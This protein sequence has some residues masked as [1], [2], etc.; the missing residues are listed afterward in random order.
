MDQV[1]REFN[2]QS[3][4]CKL[5]KTIYNS[6]HEEVDLSVVEDQTLENALE[7]KT[8][9]RFIVEVG[10]N[11]IIE[12]PVAE[13]YNAIRSMTNNKVQISGTTAQQKKR[14][15]SAPPGVC[16][17]SNLGNTCFMNSGLQCLTHSPVLYRYFLENDYS[18]EINETN[19]LG[20]GGAVALAF[21]A[22]MKEMWSGENSYFSPNDFKRVIGKYA[23]QF[24]G[25]QQQDSQELISFI[26]DGLHEDL[27]RI[28]KKPATNPVEAKGREDSVVA[29]ESWD[30]HKLRNDSIIVDKFQGQLKSTLHCPKCDNFSIIFDPFMYLSLPIPIEKNRLINVMVF[31]NSTFPNEVESTLDSDLSKL[32]N[33]PTRLTCKVSKTG[34]VSQLRDNVLE[35][36]GL[37][38]NEDHD[39]CV[40]YEIF[41]NKVYKYL[42]DGDS[43][44]G[45][46]DADIIHCQILP[47]ASEVIVSNFVT[48]GKAVEKLNNLP[49]NVH[50][51]YRQTY[52]NTQQQLP[53]LQVSLSSH[54]ANQYGRKSFQIIGTPFVVPLGQIFEEKKEDKE[55]SVPTHEDLYEYCFQ[56]MLRYVKDEFAAEI[57][58]TMKERNLTFKDFLPSKEK[59]EALKSGENVEENI[60][61]FYLFDQEGGR[62][63]V[64]D[65]SFDGALLCDE[66]EF[67]PYAPK[68]SSARTEKKSIFMH[69]PAFFHDKMLDYEKLPRFKE[70]PSTKQKISQSEAINIYQ[71]LDLYT[72]KEKLG[73]NDTW[74]CPSCKEHVEATK[75]F[76]I[77]KAPD[78]LVV[79][80]K[81]F[82]FSSY[83]RDKIDRFIDYP[84]QDLDI[85]SFVHCKD[86]NLK[87]DLFAVSD[88]FG[89]LGGGHY[90][91]CAKNHIDGKWYKFDDSR[92]SEVHNPES[93]KASSNYV[94]FYIRKE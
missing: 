34:S 29:Q 77:W 5:W 25:Y 82:S 75:K 68:Y 92:S 40:L 47:K 6:P 11:W 53:F 83:S 71:C 94:L 72:S 48:S 36:L 15:D 12:P 27:N 32:S 50:S 80:L 89:G 42:S 4:E 64:N 85:S 33:M 18:K 79:H 51:L 88:H 58:Q 62:L 9:Q 61:I 7:R 1:K 8:G 69:I 41:S 28:Q 16:G 60:S 78:V 39:R 67:K 35:L 59:L 44:S 45:I 17:L 65:R 22:L 55:V 14:Y 81:R 3:R 20:M 13:S 10:P 23:P 21:G 46:L 2:I 66:T 76:D 31:S 86:L 56:Y 52:S 93:I 90:T 87:Y 74:Y 24:A 37:N 43:I 30:V 57:E 38:T 63:E 84:I 91:A 73:A 26:L 19:P 70:H 54:T 49:K